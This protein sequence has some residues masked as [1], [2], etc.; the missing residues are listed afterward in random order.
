MLR[1]QGP[2]LDRTTLDRW[3]A[4][5]AVADLL[6]RALADALGPEPPPSTT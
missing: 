5:L 6:E 2:D 1:I 3:A 4:H